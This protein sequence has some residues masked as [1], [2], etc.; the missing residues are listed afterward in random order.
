[1]NVGVLLLAAGSSRRFGA[2]KRYARLAGGETVLDSCIATIRQA[3]LPLLVCLPPGDTRTAEVMH[4]LKVDSYH[5]ANSA[6]G[7]GATLAEGIGQVTRWQGVLVGLAD[8]PFIRASTYSAVAESLE[9]GGICVPRYRGEQGHPVGFGRLFF[10][11]L[12]GLTGD[13][14]ARRLLRQ[15]SNRITWVEVD[16]EGIRRDIDRRDDLP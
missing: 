4:R 14:G 8:M 7:M 12:A 2:D 13:Q 9:S 3:G 11:A 6:R 10:P 5:C 15:H 1:M 16:D